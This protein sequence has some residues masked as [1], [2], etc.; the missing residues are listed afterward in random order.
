MRR[1]SIF[2]LLRL[3]RLL[4]RV[5]ISTR[6]PCSLAHSPQLTVDVDQLAST[7]PDAVEKLVSSRLDKLSGGE[8]LT[9]RVAS[10]IGMQFDVP[11]LVRCVVRFV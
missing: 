2:V 8:Q 3:L 10:V 11:L 9:L 4:S 5:R 6:S 1:V 7:L